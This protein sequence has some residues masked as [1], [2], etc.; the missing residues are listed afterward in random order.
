MSA[1]GEVIDQYGRPLR[2]GYEP[3]A[4]V[5][6]VGGLVRTPWRFWRWSIVR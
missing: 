1:G 5:K 6:I 2:R 3:D 4:L